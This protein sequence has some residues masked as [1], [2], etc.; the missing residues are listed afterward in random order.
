MWCVNLTINQFG[1][2]VCC[3]ID[4]CFTYYFV[5]NSP[6]CYISIYKIQNVSNFISSINAKKKVSHPPVKLLSTNISIEITFHFLKSD[7]KPFHSHTDLQHIIHGKLCCI[8]ILYHCTLWWL[9]KKRRRKKSETETTG[10]PISNRSTNFQFEKFRRLAL[11]EK[12]TLSISAVLWFS[13]FGTNNKICRINAGHVFLPP[14][15]RFAAL[16]PVY[17]SHI[18]TYTRFSVWFGLVSPKMVLSVVH[19]QNE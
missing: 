1:F 18:F 16:T 8:W 13:C 10:K 4:E 11:V 19:F 12:F 9:T 6:N 17:P 7:I 3:Q 2:V 5:T 14:P 15:P